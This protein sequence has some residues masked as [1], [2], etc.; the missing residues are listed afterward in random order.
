MDEFI[1]DADNE[2]DEEIIPPILCSQC[3]VNESDPR[4]DYNLCI[5]CELN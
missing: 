4:S 2:E 3:Q 5:I 1:A